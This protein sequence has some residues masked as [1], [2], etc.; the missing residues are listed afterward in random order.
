MTSLVPFISVAAGGAIGATMRFGVSLWLGPVTKFP[1]PT[2]LVNMLGC[3]V[4]GVLLVLFML[5]APGG[6]AQLLLMTGLLGGFTTF[7]AFSMDT[8]RLVESGQNGLA[9]VNVLANVFGSLLA[10]FCGWWLARTLVA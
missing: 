1:T 8:L 7:S 5:R 10:V 6:S 9:L 2:L 4:A 3:F